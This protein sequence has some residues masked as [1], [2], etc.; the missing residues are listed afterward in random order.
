M[1]SLHPEVDSELSTKAEWN[2]RPASTP[3]TLS[4]NDGYHAAADRS[5]VLSLCGHNVVDRATHIDWL[6]LRD[7]SPADGSTARGA[8][9]AA[10]GV[11]MTRMPECVEFGFPK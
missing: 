2:D 7:V 8:S 6:A 9:L 10:A 4:Q 5:V 1:G 11:A 3:Q